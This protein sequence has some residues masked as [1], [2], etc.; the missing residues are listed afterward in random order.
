MDLAERA[1]LESEHFSLLTGTSAGDM[2]RLAL[3]SRGKVHSWRVHR[4]HH[5]PGASVTV[6]YCVSLQSSPHARSEPHAHKETTD[7]YILAS[8]AKISAQK[9]SASSAITLTIGD[10]RVHLWE[11][12]N[13]PELPAL[14]VASDARLLEKILG[15]SVNIEMLSYR[16]TRRAVFHIEGISDQAE[17][18]N[19][20][21]D[22]VSLDIYAKVVRP[23]AQ[24][25]LIRRLKLLEDSHIPG[26][27]MYEPRADDT[28]RARFPVLH[29]GA[30]HDGALHTHAVCD[31]HSASRSI[32]HSLPT[33]TLGSAY[34]SY[35]TP[36]S[37][38][39]PAFP[40]DSF[41]DHVTLPAGLV[42]THAAQGV[43]LSR[44][45]AGIDPKDLGDADLMLNQL[46]EILDALPQ[47][48]AFFPKKPAWADRCEHYA[49]AAGVA[50]PTGAARAQRIA[51]QIRY[52]FERADFG[53]IIAVHGDFYEANVLIDP[54]SQRI[55]A[56]LDVDSLGPGYRA[57]DWG[58]LLG[59]LA[60][61]PSLAP[62]RYGWA[63]TLCARWFDQLSERVDPVALC[64]S[65]A[66]VVLSL[67]AGGAKHRKGSGNSDSSSSNLAEARLCAAEEWIAA[68]LAIANDPRFNAHIIELAR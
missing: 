24:A 37:T 38:L 45:Y 17:N 10:T 3:A 13:D 68:G 49:H 36:S 56:L 48:A 50:Y 2:L 52:L 21:D 15:T 29:D 19:K 9:L 27:R 67:V 60:V 11:Y 66:G 16:P 58:C 47:A 65:T 12:P 39:A 44:F 63:E 59:H 22:D 30:A 55:S 64:A 40:D 51:R 54:Q 41:P 23:S 32:P 43:P 26:I 57:H 33:S 6:G 61:L 46:E 34:S 8:T 62:T 1:R 53:K 28:L 14:T 25:D 4:V 20:K 18:G 31:P 7:L 5:R 42:L 35:V